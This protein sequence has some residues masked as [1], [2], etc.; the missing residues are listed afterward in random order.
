MKTIQGRIKMKV[1]RLNILIGITII[2]IWGLSW[3]GLGSPAYGDTYEKV[4]D[5][6]GTIPNRTLDVAV[7]DT[8]GDGKP[9]I[10]VSDYPT[11]G[12]AKIYVF[13]NTGDNSYQLVWNSGTTLTMPTCFIAIGDQDSDEKK[14]IIALEC[15]GESPFPGK[16]HVFENN[17]DNAYQEVWDSGNALNG[18]EPGT[19]ILGDDADNDGKREIIIG[20]GYHADRKI[21]V[22]ENTGDNVYQ[23][24]WISDSLPDQPTPG[25]VGDTDG[26][27][28]KEIIVGG[29]GVDSR[30]HVFECNGYDSYMEVWNGGATS[31]GV[32]IGDQDA[33]GK[34]EIIPAGGNAGVVHVFE[35][36]GDN[37]YTDV[38]NSGTMG[39]TSLVA[40]GDQDRDGKREIIVPCADG[41][42]Y[43]FENTGDNAYQEVWNSGSVMSGFI[44]RVTAGDQDADGKFEIIATS[45]DKKVYVFENVCPFGSINGHVTDLAGNPIKWAIVIAI[46][47][48][49]KEKTWDVTNA[50]GYYEI[51]ELPPGMYLL[52]VIKSGYKAGI[53]KV[54]VKACETTT[55]DFKLKPKSGEDNEDEFAALYANY[56][57]PFNPDTWIPY[58]LP[59]DANVTIQ[60][61]N[62]AGQM[63]RELNL[64]R[65]AAGIYLNKD[66]AAYWDGKDSLGQ[67]VSSG[68]YF[69][70]IHAG[71]FTVT[72]K[73][74]I[75]K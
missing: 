2:V 16:L 11:S 68:V 38:W 18:L 9:E 72:R 5:S 15:Y 61:Y 4:W 20:S 17:G 32:T 53:A 59:Q 43:L 28:K 40:T 36:T 63:V 13:E 25:A 48:G 35:N 23:V 6:G 37:T 75:M 51:L 55:K 74:V 66:S 27:G 73:M 60:I 19:L 34:A 62:S 65:Q 24:V 69:Y 39:F 49:T 7:G 3:T 64:G 29:G 26:D 12:G 1:E 14:E 33:D 21:R 30:C 22:Y 56:P 41:K 67:L 52:I 44:H 31:S 50:D 70:T 42:V 8:D 71:K 10:I 58:Y 45:E 46:N 54:E 57:N 47:I